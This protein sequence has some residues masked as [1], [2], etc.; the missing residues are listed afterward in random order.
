[1]GKTQEDW[2]SILPLCLN[3]NAWKVRLQ[4]VVVATFLNTFIIWLLL[5]PH[6]VDKCWN[7]HQRTYMDVERIVNYFYKKHEV[8]NL[9]YLTIFLFYNY[10]FSWFFLGCDNQSYIYNKLPIGCCKT[11]Q[12]YFQV[13]TCITN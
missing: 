7:D 12:H 1:M 10:M 4:I 5:S 13:P 9:P 2:Y 3:F 8:V 11:R 6:F